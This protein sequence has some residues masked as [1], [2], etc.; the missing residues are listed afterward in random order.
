VRLPLVILCS[1]PVFSSKS[2]LKR[3]AVRRIAPLALAICGVPACG[4]EAWGGAC[5]GQTQ[6]ITSLRRAAR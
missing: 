4:A 2:A 5:D 1:S 6:R 3:P